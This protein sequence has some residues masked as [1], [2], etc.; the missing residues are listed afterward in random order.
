[1][2]TKEKM[3]PDDIKKK[4]REKK[5]TRYEQVAGRRE[6]RTPVKEDKRTC[7]VCML[8]DALWYHVVAARRQMMR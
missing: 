3:N 4:K 2:A 8:F 6:K 1:M 5:N 7:L